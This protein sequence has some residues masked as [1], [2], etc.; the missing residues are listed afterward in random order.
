MCVAG[1]RQS[2]IT[3][4][5]ICAPPDNVAVAFSLVGAMVNPDRDEEVALSDIEQLLTSYFEMCAHLSTDVAR[6][7]HGESPAHVAALTVKRYTQS[8]YGM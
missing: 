1:Q 5:F 8:R 4:I 7:F 3:C 6:A 2:M